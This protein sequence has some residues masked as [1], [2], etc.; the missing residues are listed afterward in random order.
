MGTS[1]LM[2]KFASVKSPT[3]KPITIGI[4]MRAPPALGYFQPKTRP[5]K[6]N[7][8]MDSATFSHN[9]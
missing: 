4:T 2:L 5:I 7:G 8:I 3:I 9:E 6:T 1:K